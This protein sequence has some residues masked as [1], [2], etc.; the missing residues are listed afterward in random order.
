M[1]N[2]FI[3]LIVFITLAF[4]FAW[5]KKSELNKY[6]NS[7]SNSE[8]ISK[9]PENLIFKDMELIKDVRPS[10]YFS[11]GSDILFL[12]F[13]ATWCS[14]CEKEFPQFEK[15]LTK[16]SKAQNSL[17]VS[18]VFVAINDQQKLIEG[19]LKRFPALKDKIYFLRD[20]NEIYKKFLGTTQVPDTWI[21]GKNESVLKRFTGPQ[22][23]SQDYY[24]KIFTKN[25]E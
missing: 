24:L 17:K 11:E 20:N 18:F 4:S 23:W 13:W 19:F 1:T 22:D 10:E 9:L 25:A 15:L 3:S 14:P 21:F 8:L 12:H 7:A 16:L 5:Y 6:L 2:R